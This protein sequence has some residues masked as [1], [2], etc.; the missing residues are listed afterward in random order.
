MPTRTTPVFFDASTLANFKEWAQE[1]GAALLAYGWIKHT[2]TG[3]IDWT[4]AVLP[5]AGA[6]MAGYEAYTPGDGLTPFYLRLEYGR[7]GVNAP[8]V[9]F[10]LSSAMAADGTPL[11]NTTASVQ[12]V[13]NAA[14]TASR[15]NMY[16]SGDSARFG[17]LCGID[18]TTA[19]L[20]VGWERSRDDGGVYTNDG[21]CTIS[22]PGPL[23]SQYFT[24]GA[25]PPPTHT[26]VIPLPSNFS[27]HAYGGEAPVAP[28]LHWRG[29]AV[30]PMTQFMYG[31]TGDWTNG[32]INPVEVY[33]V[34]RNYM[35]A[36]ASGSHGLVSNTRPALRWD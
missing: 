4:T 6:F 16:S 24:I 22:A 32:S 26:P 17:F 29:R 31:L 23:S 18:N 15:T 3:Q 5:A 2:S 25:T 35:F 9:R 11:G 19:A 12:A 34:S 13:G 14:I 21:V 27:S 28:C 33:G 7:G 8:I 1:I 36:T 30:N 10:R 20:F